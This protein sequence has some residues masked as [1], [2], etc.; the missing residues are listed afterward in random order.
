MLDT[1]KFKLYSVGRVA[2][3][4]KMSEDTVEVMPVETIS[5]LDGEIKSN[6]TTTETKGTDAQGNAYQTSSESDNTVPCKW[7]P[8]G[9]NRVT[10][11]DWR[12][13]ERVLIYQYGDEDLYYCV[14]MGWDRHLRKLETVVYA[15]SATTDESDTSINKDNSYAFEVSTHGKHITLTT[16]DKNGE[17]FKYTFQF[18]TGDGVVTLTDDAGNFIEL[19]SAATKIT[20]QNVDGTMLTLDKETIIGFC[21]DSMSYTATN[22][23]N[24]EC[25][26]FNVKSSET[27]IVASSS[28]NLTTP[29]TNISGAVNMGGGG[30]GSCHVTGPIVSSDNIS[31]ASMDVAGT[32]RCGKLISREPISAPNV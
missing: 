24:F 30:G 22:N 16:T 25:T 11:P 5:F 1:S 2:E 21:K 12:R 10:A 32:I 14:S 27:N 19:D 26:T 9:D 6:P 23:I 18:N 8:L 28:T 29:V 20:F 15:W 7:L 17:P 13:G 4:K 3:N 31:A